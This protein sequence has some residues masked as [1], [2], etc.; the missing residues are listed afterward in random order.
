MKYRS[1]DLIL[2]DLPGGRRS[3]PSTVVSV[4]SDGYSYTIETDDGDVYVLPIKLIRRS[5][6]KSPGRKAFRTGDGS[7]TA[8]SPR[9]VRSGGVSKSPARKRSLSRT[10][11]PATGTR[12]RSS[13]R[14]RV[15]KRD[16]NSVTGKDFFNVLAGCF[17]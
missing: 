5:R 11:T 7:S 4:D 3:V 8:I 6:R 16:D 9:R 13:S 10:R 1:G 17:F 14:N 15:Q 12:R 2:A